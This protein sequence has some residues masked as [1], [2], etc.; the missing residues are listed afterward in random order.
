MADFCYQCTLEYFGPRF[1]KKNDMRGLVQKD[2]IAGVLCEGCGYI[3]V[4]HKGKCITSQYEDI[5]SS[6]NRNYKC[7]KGHKVCKK[8]MN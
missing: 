1:A 8:K 6:N 7:E 5:A 3:I 4:D 2:E